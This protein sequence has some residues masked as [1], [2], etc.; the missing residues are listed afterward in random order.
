[1][2]IEFLCHFNLIIK[3]F[4]STEIEFGDFLVIFEESGYLT[5]LQNFLLLWLEL[6]VCDRS[7]NFFESL[8]ILV[9]LLAC[10]L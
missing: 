6:R 9:N 3:I 4:T 1:M 8:I 7:S 5:M 10:A 2:T